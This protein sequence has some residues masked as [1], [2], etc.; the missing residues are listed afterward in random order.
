MKSTPPN[1]MSELLLRVEGVWYSY[2]RPPGWGNDGSWVLRDVSFC[3][4]RNQSLGI[5]GHS[6]S[7]KTTLALA[8]LGL[9]RPSRGRVLLGDHDLAKL[10][11]AE[12]RKLCPRLQ[13]VF[14]EGGKALPPHFTV[15]EAVREPIELH[16][17]HPR[18]LASRAALALAGADHLAK[19]RAIGSL[20]F[21]EAQR[22]A[23]AR[24]IVTIPDLLVCD[25]PTS[26]LDLCTQAHVLRTLLTLRQKF[27]TGL[28]VITHNP[29][30]AATLCTHILVLHQ[31]VVVEYGP[32]RYLL[33]WARHPFSR[34]LF[35]TVQDGLPCQK[36]RGASS[37]PEAPA[38]ALSLSYM[39][40]FF[41]PP[42]YLEPEVGHFVRAAQSV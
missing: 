40:R 30:V 22:V 19:D 8:I 7:G 14:Q 13:I 23:L 42:E 11:S 10:T 34:E 29:L 41:R 35:G 17:A 31:G 36:Q 25:E 12:R 33:S 5:V 20:S 37:E 16:P 18:R 4:E 24:A 27:S 32:T 3:L 28:I 38:N 9:N 21:G 2:R 1:A 39:R 6:G 26:A 15:D